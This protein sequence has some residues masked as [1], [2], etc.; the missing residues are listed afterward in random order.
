MS[1]LLS[2]PLDFP[3]HS[4]RLIEA[5]A[6]TGKTYTIAAL[7][8]RLVIGHGDPDQCF[9]RELIPKNILV[10]TF[11]KAATEELSDRIRARLAEAASY[12]RQPDKISD[13]AFLA[14]LRDDCEQRQQNLQHLARLL[15]LA[16]QSMDE[17]AVKTIH[18]W[19]QAMLK[20][21]AFASGSLFSQ[22]VET[23]DD[24]LRLQAAEDYFRHFVYS[25]EETVA[26]RLLNDFGTPQQLLSLT[27]SLSTTSSINSSDNLAE[28]LQQSE[29]GHQQR[30]VAIKQHLAP[31][32][33]LSLIH[34]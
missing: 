34:I 10:M 1:H 11:T 20:E 12:F 33:N 3:L 6:G 26:E 24:E 14:N 22:N 18:G 21:H 29:E 27:Y 7:Y 16:S 19:C 23:E 4:S 30:V 13:D 15:D 17:A 25:A 2:N 5:S 32:I 8:V 9:P 28:L 31:L